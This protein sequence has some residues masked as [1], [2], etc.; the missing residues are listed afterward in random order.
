MMDTDYE[1]VERDPVQIYVSTSLRPETTT[2]RKIFKSMTVKQ[3]KNR[4][5]LLTGA[6]PDTM[7]L[8]LYDSQVGDN[9]RKMIKDPGSGYFGI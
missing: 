7:H 1:F 3:L 6:D 8:E 2:E 9:V 4:L 5:E